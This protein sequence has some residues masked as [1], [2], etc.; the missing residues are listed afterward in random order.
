VF[1]DYRPTKDAFVV[2]R[3]RKAGAIILGKTT[4]SEF[5]AGDTYGSLFG[6]TRNPYD[7]RRT[8]GGSSGGSGAALAA[9]FATLAFGEETVA[10]IR[11]PGAWNAIVSLRPT[12]G[13]VSRSGMWDGYPSPTA[14]MGPMARSVRDLAQLL[15]AMGRLRSRGSSH[16]AWGRSR[17]RQLHHV[18]GRERFE[19]R[20]DRCSPRIDRRPIGIGIAGLQEG[21]CRL[22]E[23]RCGAA[24]RWRHHHRS[25]CDPRPE[26]AAGQ[27]SD[28]PGHR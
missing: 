27:T 16:G 22:P 17:A 26:R 21:R 9:N 5:A 25:R 13:L 8:V 6:V 15:D 7:V 18:A 4:L 2:E 23:E 20:A 24:S 10:S 19:G 1:K 12:P 14:Q 3:L 28:Q 11:R